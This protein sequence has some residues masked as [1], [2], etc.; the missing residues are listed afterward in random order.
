MSLVRILFAVASVSAVID[1]GKIYIN[2]SR[3]DKVA[4]LV[5]FAIMG[6]LVAITVITSMIRRAASAS[7]NSQ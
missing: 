1:L 4:L 3:V 7:R 6:I 5:D 2:A